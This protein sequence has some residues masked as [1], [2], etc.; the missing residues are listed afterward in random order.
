MVAPVRTE[1]NE[2]LVKA[3]NIDEPTLREAAEWFKEATRSRAFLQ[4]VT[5][6]ELERL[7]STW[8]ILVRKISEREGVATGPL[9]GFI[10]HVADM[11]LQ[12][13]AA[14]LNEAAEALDVGE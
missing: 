5:R 4:D 8:K 6:F 11:D 2:L 9:S 13:H 14:A 12:L 1:I 3:D 10:V 7:D